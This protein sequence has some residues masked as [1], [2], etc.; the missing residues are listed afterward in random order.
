[1]G[2]PNISIIFKTLATSA[3]SRSERGI[4]ALILNDSTSKTSYSFNKLADVDKDNFTSENY[5]YIRLAFLGNP[6][7]VIVEIA[8]DEDLSEVLK[9]LETK[10]V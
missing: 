10:K 8:N 3:I 7:K 9:R 5:D 1:M 6:N 4:V 2:L